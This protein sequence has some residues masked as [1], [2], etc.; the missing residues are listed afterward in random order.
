LEDVTEDDWNIKRE[1]IRD[2]QKLERAANNLIVR[3]KAWIAEHGL[4]KSGKAPRIEIP[5]GGFTSIRRDD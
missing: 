5:A 2:E 1:E 3:G 4:N